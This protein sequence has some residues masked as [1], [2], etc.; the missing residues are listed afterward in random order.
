MGNR[1]RLGT[2]A[3]EEASIV[4][5]GSF[6]PAI[7]QPQWLAKQSLIRPEEAKHAEGEKNF[8]VTRDLAVIRLGWL[9]LQVL[10]DRFTATT[11]D[12]SHFETLL[13]CVSGIFQFLEFTPVTA[14]GVNCGLHWEL[15]DSE[16]WPALEEAVA[17]KDMWQELLS[18]PHNG[19]LQLTSLSLRG[20]R[21]GSPAEY[22]NVKVEPSARVPQG[23]FLHT[24]EHYQ[25]APN[26]PAVESMGILRH[27][28]SGALAATKQL[29]SS[30]IERTTN[31]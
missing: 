14:M 12:P 29:A 13:E 30:L 8:V 26:T 20:E 23:L 19:P 18:G 31:A 24:N 9:D 27:N 28:W 5:L 21:D 11:S 3:I 7:L 1:L 2:P 6:N 10:P 22:V 16:T 17:P 4:L 25:F 15:S